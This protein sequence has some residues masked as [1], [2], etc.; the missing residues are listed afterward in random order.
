MILPDGFFTIDL[1]SPIVDEA[2]R[3]RLRYVRPV[4]NLETGVGTYLGAASLDGP[5]SEVGECE[6]ALSAKGAS[7]AQAV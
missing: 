4:L 2:R 3:R 1:S 6:I 7:D 5:W